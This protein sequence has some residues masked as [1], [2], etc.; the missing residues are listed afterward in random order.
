[1]SNSYYIEKMADCQWSDDIGMGRREKNRN[2]YG[3]KIE[4]KMMLYIKCRT[5]RAKKSMT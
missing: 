4:I 5:K 1:M 2:N 3:E